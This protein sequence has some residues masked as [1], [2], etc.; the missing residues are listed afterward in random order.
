MWDYSVSFSLFYFF[1]FSPHFNG[2]VVHS[3]LMPFMLLTHFLCNKSDRYIHN[4]SQKIRFDS[5]DRWNMSRPQNSIDLKWIQ[6]VHQQWCGIER[7]D[8]SENIKWTSQWLNFHQ[9]NVQKGWSSSNFAKN[10]MF[11]FE[12]RETSNLFWYPIRTAGSMFGLTNRFQKVQKQIDFRSL[13][14]MVSI[15]SLVIQLWLT[16]PQRYFA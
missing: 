11:N 15:S 13:F 14:I 16:L 9:I 8:W 3:K 5:F 6:R 7:V 10:G 4:N 2:Q 1:I 12:I